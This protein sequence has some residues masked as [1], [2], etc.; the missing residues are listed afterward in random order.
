MKWK[1]ET[2]IN[3]HCGAFASRGN[4]LKV[5]ERMSSD[6]NQI[7]KLKETQHFINYFFLFIL[8]SPQFTFD[9]ICQFLLYSQKDCF[10]HLKK[11]IFFN[12]IVCRQNAILKKLE[13]RQ[14]TL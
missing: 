9:A 3:L 8:F 12:L 10:F 11:N 5:C 2:K 4:A 6:Q 1:D 7:S 14:I 13:K